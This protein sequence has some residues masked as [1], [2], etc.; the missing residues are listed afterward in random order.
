M[1]IR[2]IRGQVNKTIVIDDDEVS[3]TIKC[4]G[5]GIKIM[6]NENITQVEGTVGKIDT[7]G[8]KNTVNWQASQD[9]Q[10]KISNWGNKN[11]LKAKK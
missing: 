3:K 7:P 8:N 10:P 4:N 6:G 11:K 5:H 1:V 9:P 2:V